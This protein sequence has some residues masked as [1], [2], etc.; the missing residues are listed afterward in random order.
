MELGYHV[1]V[2]AT[3]SPDVDATRPLLYGTVLVLLLLTFAAQPDRD[4]AALPAARAAGGEAVT[5]TRGALEHDRYATADRAAPPRA[6]RAAAAARRAAAD[7]RR[8]GRR[9]RPADFSL[10][11][12]THQALKRVSTRRCRPHSVTAIIG[13]S[14][15]GKSTLLRSFNRMNDLI[16]GV[17]I[18]GAIAV[19]G[20][21]VLAPAT[22]VVE[23][24]RRVGM[25]FQRPNPFPK[26]IFEN[27][28]VRPAHARAAATAPSSRRASRR[29]C[30][31]RRCGTR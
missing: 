30:G 17:R 7:P 9:S 26:S 20:R 6:A 29:A 21:D 15:C 2:L 24:R 19:A 18:E 25:V 4:P 12:G 11:Y 13:P 5:V 28:G 1:F 16:P 27:V 10:F 31:A 22:D 3:Q 14:G 23:L 8:A